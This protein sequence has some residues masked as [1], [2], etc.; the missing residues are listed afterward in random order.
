MEAMCCRE[1]ATENAEVARGNPVAAVKE[2]EMRQSS[3]RHTA[4]LGCNLTFLGLRP[5]D[6]NGHY[7]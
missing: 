7:F 1:A 4:H 2:E 6:Y 5:I 3:H